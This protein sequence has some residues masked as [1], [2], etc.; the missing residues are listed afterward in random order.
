M[1]PV[2]CSDDVDNEDYV[3]IALERFLTF[4]KTCDPNPTVEKACELRD[5]QVSSEVVWW[6]D[7]GAAAATLY[8]EMDGVLSRFGNV[9]LFHAQFTR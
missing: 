3:Q 6:R 5:N 2:L 4:S 9:V 1:V 8:R 7:Y